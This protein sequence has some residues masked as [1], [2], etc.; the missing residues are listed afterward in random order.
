LG[1][2]FTRFWDK[3]QDR[4]VDQDLPLALVSGSAAIEW[5]NDYV[6][7]LTGVSLPFSFGDF[8]LQPWAVAL[9]VSVSPF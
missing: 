4:G 8:Q 1:L 6:A 5:S 9:G 7:V 3:D 2:A